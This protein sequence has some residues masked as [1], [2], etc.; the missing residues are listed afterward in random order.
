MK[1]A[2]GFVGLIGNTPLVRLDRLGAETGCEILGKAEFLNPAVRSRT[3]PRSTSFAMPSGAACS[4]RAARWS[5][6]RPAIPA[7]LRDQ[8]CFAMVDRLLRE[9]GLF[10]G[11]SSGINVAA[12]VQV[13]RQLGRGTRW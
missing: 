7:H 4:S 3:G 1:F 13:A 10:L 9:E 11:S 6:A 8:S 2:D 5:R 12:T